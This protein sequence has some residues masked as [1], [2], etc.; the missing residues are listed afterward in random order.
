MTAECF[1]VLSECDACTN[2]VLVY[3]CFSALIDNAL[4]E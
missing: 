1:T 3:N 4:P 2:K